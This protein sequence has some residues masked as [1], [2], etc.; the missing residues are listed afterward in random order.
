MEVSKKTG[1][2]TCGCLVVFILF[3]AVWAYLA[4]DK[5]GRQAG[6]RQVRPRCD[7]ASVDLCQ[8]IVSNDP[9]LK[10][11]FR[12]PDELV[13]ALENCKRLRDAGCW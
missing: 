3:L 6:E 10:G 4:R 9:A 2:W 7:S 12:S 5:G 8:R 11:F 1:D 13:L